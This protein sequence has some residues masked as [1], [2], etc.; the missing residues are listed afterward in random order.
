MTPTHD[1]FDFE[2]AVREFEGAYEKAVKD[3]GRFNLL[4]FGKTGVGKSTLINAVFGEEVAKTGSGR[5]VTVK[6]EYFEHPSGILGIYDSEG[7]EVGE[8]GDEIIARFRGIIAETRHRDLSEQIHVIWYCVLAGNQRF[9]DGQ[10]RFVEAF[11]KEGLPILIVLTQVG[12]R[13][14]QVKPAVRDL[15][16]S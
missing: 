16:R 5:P 13:N 6:T 7:I 4:I 10:A 15:E 11:A 8:E 14:G 9:E 2:G 3:L 12:M 1:S